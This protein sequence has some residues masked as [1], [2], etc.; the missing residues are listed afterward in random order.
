MPAPALTASLRQFLLSHVPFAQMARA[1]L[2]ELISHVEV[3]YFGPGE[4]VL[5]AA[6]GVPEYA[7]IIKQGRVQGR[8]LGVQGGQAVLELGAGES[9]ALGAL[10][11]QRPANL[12]YVSLAD[13]FCLLL[14]RTQFEALTRRSEVFLNFC[15]DSLGQLLDLSHQQV[16]ASYAL[17]AGVEHNLATPLGELMRTPALH[18]APDEPLR[19][20]LERMHAAAVGSVIVVQA[21]QVC[22]ILTLTDLIGRVL[23]PEVALHTPVREVMTR[24]VATLNITDTAADAMVLMAGQGVRHVPVMAQDGD[25][26]QL[27]GVVSERNLFTLQRLSVRSLGVTLRQAADVAALAVVAADVRHLSHHLV[28]QGVGA[29]ALTRVVSGL[30]DQ[31]TARVLQ[32]ACARFDVS[33][34]HFCW[35]A[36][37]SEGRCEQTIATDQDNALVFDAARLSHAQMLELAGWANEALATIGFPLCTGGVMA[38]NPRW[39]LSQQQWRVQFE[40]WID[41]GDPRSLLEASIFFDFRGLYGRLGMAAELRS[42]VVQR[43]SRNERFLKQMADNALRNRA[44]QTGLFENWLGSTTPIDIKLHGTVLLVDAARIWALAAG[45]TSTHMPTHTPTR[46]RL[47]VTQGR[48]PEREVAAWI[49]AFEFLQLLRLRVQHEG[50]A[51]AAHPNLVHPDALSAID[52]R[53]LKESLRQARKA[54]Q[55]LMLDYPG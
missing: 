22:G 28:A 11:A 26:R 54:Q 36:L 38:R 37:G 50:A 32:L 34:E 25:T 24:N 44:A 2:D 19:A 20:V 15:R 30:N 53:I 39:C 52:Q 33:V 35:L 16:Q 13:T 3:A 17:R 9:F 45:L 49:D 14:S 27:R 40:E 46:L 48:L 4:V 43:A 42:Q 47:C 7:V 21:H 31:L 6:A 1:D 12:E 10:L 51:N 5:A 8:T 55:R 23:L 29:A 41:Q 18:C